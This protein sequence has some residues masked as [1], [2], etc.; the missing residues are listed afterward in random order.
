M[1]R[2][3]K[4][5]S[6]KVKIILCLIT[7]VVILAVILSVI[8]G[9]NNKIA[10]VYEVTVKDLVAATPEDVQEACRPDWEY[11]SSILDKYDDCVWVWC[12]GDRL[13]A[14]RADRLELKSEN[15]TVSAM[16]EVHFQDQ[17][18]RVREGYV[19]DLSSPPVEL[20]KIRLT[21]E[22]RLH[23]DD[24]SMTVR[25]GI[26]SGELSYEDACYLWEE[27]TDLVYVV[28]QSEVT[29]AGD[30]HGCFVDDGGRMR[31]CYILDTDIEG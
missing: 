10:T 17:H 24:V 4:A 3:I 15:S 20:A 22:H 7:A 11:Y 29:P 13:F 18:K 31:V 9:S 23:F 28:P 6:D 14:V 19:I 25:C 1:F 26:R 27:G 2:R 21:A 30:R 12:G 5:L 16:T 8:I